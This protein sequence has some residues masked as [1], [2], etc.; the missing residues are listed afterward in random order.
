MIEY[1]RLK[2]DVGELT[3]V[4]IMNTGD[5][6]GIWTAYIEEYPGVVTQGEN[7]EVVMARLPV[8]LDLMLEV[9]IKSMM[10]NN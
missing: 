2:T 8:I 10:D 5:H 6:D 7:M 3:A 4:F 9:Q 1:R